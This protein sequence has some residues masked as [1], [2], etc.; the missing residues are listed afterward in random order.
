LAALPM[1][2]ERGLI[3]ADERIA[4]FD[5]GA[6]FKSD[7]QALDGPAVVPNDP[8]AWPEVIARLG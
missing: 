1:L 3:G 2:L 5:T 4:L 6:G 8:N 7:A